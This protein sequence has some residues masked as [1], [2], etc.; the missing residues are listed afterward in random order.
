M[1]RKFSWLF[2]AGS[3]LVCTV[4]HA[5]PQVVRP[6]VSVKVPA[7]LGLGQP[8]QDEPAKIGRLG[9]SDPLVQQK[10]LNEPD[11]M[12]FLRGTYSEACARGY[13]H[14][15]LNRMKSDKDLE[16][17]DS[18][19]QAAANLISSKR[20]WKLTSMEMEGIFG[21]EYLKVAN[22]CDCLMQ[23][24]S[25]ADLVNPKKGLEVIKA[26]PEST[27]KTCERIALEKAQKQFATTKAAR[28]AQEPSK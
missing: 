24:V 25:D 27:Q 7:R 19:R 26:L 1:K 20:V 16:I 17:A 6:E 12:R 15:M 4:A 18:G 11:M 22:H 3:I 9:L 2:V 23:E 5:G 8:A 10:Y 28:A 14:D 13:V 21:I